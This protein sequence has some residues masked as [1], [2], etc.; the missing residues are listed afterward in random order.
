M[1]CRSAS[2][3]PEQTGTLTRSSNTSKC[4][5]GTPHACEG[6]TAACDAWTER[7]LRGFTEAA[8]T[9][10]GLAETRVGLAASVTWHPRLLVRGP[11]DL[12]EGG[13]S[14]QCASRAGARAGGD[15]AAAEQRKL[16][17][18]RARPSR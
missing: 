9:G 15:A 18:I 17:R 6:T 2:P 4:L 8:G 1:C 10:L 13:W 5:T 3:T 14:V 12:Q 11:L 16:G 7:G